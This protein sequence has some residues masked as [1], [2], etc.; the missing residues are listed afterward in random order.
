MKFKKMMIVSII[1]LA[2]LTIG[3]VSASGDMDTLSQDSTDS[4]SLLNN[5]TFV[6]DEEDSCIFYSEGHINLSDAD[7]DEQTVMVAQF[8]CETAGSITISD[9]NN[10][11][12]LRKDIGQIH[13]G[14][15]Y[16]I[17]YGDIKNLDYLKTQDNILYLNFFNT[18]GMRSGFGAF[19]VVNDQ[20]GFGFDPLNPISDAEFRLPPC[21]VDPSNGDSV[22]AL[23]VADEGII[24]SLDIF[25]QDDCIV[26]GF[27]INYNDY[28]YD[29]ETDDDG[30]VWYYIP[31]SLFNFHELEDGSIVN[32]CFT[33]DTSASKEEGFRLV[34][35]DPD[36][37][38]YFESLDELPS[39]NVEDHVDLDGDSLVASLDIPCDELGN[40]EY[41]GTLYVTLNDE[42]DI[43]VKEINQDT[44]SGDDL[45]VEIR[46]SDLNGFEGVEE[47]AVIEF[48]FITNDDP[49][50]EEN[51]RERRYFKDCRE[52]GYI[53]LQKADENDF[54]A[55]FR[56]A[57]VADHDVAISVPVIQE[58][59]GNVSKFIIEI[60]FWGE[61]I[62]TEW[63]V[64]DITIEDWA[65]TWTTT[66]L[67]IDDKMWD[68]SG[69]VDCEV[70]ITRIDEGDENEYYCN[71]EIIFFNTPYI[72]CGEISIFDDEREPAVQFTY[73]PEC[74]D[75]FII[76]IRKD[77]A[78]FADKTFKISE[79]G[80]YIYDDYY[81]LFLDDL[82][83]TE[84]G[85][86]EVSV[87]FNN[88]GPDGDQKEYTS[89]FKAVEFTI[90]SY[91]TEGDVAEDITE[92]VFRI[93]LGENDTGY[94]VI[95]VNG[96]QVFNETLSNM[97]YIEFYRGP[98]YY[99]RLNSLNITQSGYYNVELTVVTPNYNKR[100]VDTE[101]YVNVTENTFAFKD[102]LYTNFGMDTH[103]GTPI[104]PDSEIALYLNG[105]KA[106]VVDEL[107]EELD[108][109][110]NEGY[111]DILG[112]LWPGVYQGRLE[113]GGKTVAQDRFEVK[114]A[115]GNVEID[116]YQKNNGIYI[117]FK[118][119]MPEGNL[120]DY[121]LDVWV[122]PIDSEDIGDPDLSYRDEELAEILDNTAHSLY[123]GGYESGNHNVYVNYMLHNEYV[124][125]DEQDY[126]IRIFN[127]T[128]VNTVISA[129]Y[130]ADAKELI[131]TLTNN[132]TGQPIKGATVGFK[133]NGKSYTSK[134]DA[135]GQGSV[136]IADLAP[137]TYTATVSYNGNSNYNSAK[138][139]VSVIVKADTVLSTE[140]DA[141]AEELIATLTN[142]ATGQPIKGF[143]IRT[144]IDGKTY[145]AGTDANGQ[146][147]FST[148]DL[149]PGTYTAT[150]TFNGGSKYNPAST[151]QK[152]IIKANTTLSVNYNDDNTQLIAT[153]TNNAT[154]QPIKG[155]TLRVNLNGKT[156]KLVTDA[157]GQVSLSTA[158]LAPKTYPVTVTFNGG[159][160]YYPTT[161]TENI[162]VRANT[163]IDAVFDEDANELTATLIN[164]ANGKAL[165]WGNLIV[166]IN[167][168]DYTIKTNS[169][170]QAK[171]SING[172]PGGTYPTTISYGG[173][174][175]YRPSTTSLD[176][177]VKGGTYFIV[178][179]VFA[180]YGDV[181][182]VA[183]LING[184]NNQSVKGATVAFKINGKSY[185]AKTDS[186]GLVKVTV[187]G[188][189]AG[190]YSATV[191]Y[192]GNSKYDPAN[193]AFNVV[194]NKISTHI[195]AYYDSQTNEIVATLINDA[196]GKGVVGGT[197][198]FV[199]NKVKTLVK[200]D[201][202]GMA[203][204]SLEGFDLTSFKVSVSYGGN[205][206][207]LGS[208]R[209]LFGETNK[210]V[211]YISAA[212]DSET[213]EIVATLI[214]TATGKGVVGGTVGIAINGERNLIKTDSNGQAKVSA[215]D[216]PQGVYTIE[217][218][219]SGNTKYSGT[220]ET[221]DLVKF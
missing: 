114:D 198:G 152:I 189:A 206:K 108:F 96:T 41:S 62:A 75:E 148:A 95:K 105:K 115:S 211:T 207:Y 179:D 50:D 45:P 168:V 151:T 67:G 173:H 61:I 208:I 112:N 93:A 21:P 30:R 9:V 177:V 110:F 60:D 142:D 48:R 120:E 147:K 191:S 166:N 159:T 7:A 183:T 131:A 125:L 42:E 11:E 193:A 33:E 89:T 90:N 154:N 196:T 55:E 146:A 13:D 101:F 171:L 119:P 37:R 29:V 126:F 102:C 38:V 195:E 81:S 6:V 138:T 109:V 150:V 169:S 213:E 199:I 36:R 34:I 153:L 74:D 134:T 64:Y 16:S 19:Y 43:F 3:A 117:Q 145:K 187:S 70:T 72:S 107:H 49:E 47:G 156:T 219:Y 8:S 161:T 176:V 218:S 202:N 4:D 175:K 12:L 167:G 39:I 144:V 215:A 118:A 10:Y 23:V 172:L 122:D 65:Y 68:I 214:N 205:A 99:I 2:I 180:E 164:D 181:D 184:V 24:G 149:A 217:S 220:S 58:S 200:S 135:N 113:I 186:A 56:E 158:D 140:Y 139:T 59:F 91:Y 204:F 160:K 192:A 92:P 209:A 20:S 123:V 1:L 79:M 103:L 69:A 86:Y 22:I 210:I 132:V 35:V 133:I 87:I 157:N 32:F 28:E 18:V 40:I 71:G 5:A 130:D 197:V 80:Q 174:T 201:S 221:I 85:E 25:V 94:A 54:D 73:F 155:F 82:G 182:L 98:G 17:T 83:I 77:G 194:V 84:L 52:D 97:G 190:N 31:S 212:Y 78:F 124:P 141:N 57:N 106:A 165:G 14:D 116:A 162:L 185:T 137:G 128:K 104:S 88:V 188:L 178:E 136:S 27:E 111:T 143:T 170:G 26:Q 203:R 15:E 46:L 129:V 163:S 216:F 100:T 51:I 76:S 53:E 121:C 127:I 44:V 66:D 63:N